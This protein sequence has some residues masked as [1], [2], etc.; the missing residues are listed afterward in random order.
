MSMELTE[1]EHDLVTNI[2]GDKVPSE[3]QSVGTDQL[4]VMHDRVTDAV[5]LSY[6]DT[7]VESLTILLPLEE[8]LVQTLHT[9][10]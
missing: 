7:Y 10:L 2:W 5:Q 6:E 8:K 1:H 9:R 3:L 4:W